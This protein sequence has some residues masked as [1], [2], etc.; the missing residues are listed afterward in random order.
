V[1]SDIATHSRAGPP[2][3]ASGRTLGAAGSRFPLPMPRRTAISS[4]A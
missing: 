4:A 2:R 1:A 3:E